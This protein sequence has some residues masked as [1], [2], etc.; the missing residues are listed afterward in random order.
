MLFFGILNVSVVVTLYFITDGEITTLLPFLLLYSCTI[1][2]ISL[3]FSKRSVKKAF[4]LYVL[5]PDQSYDRLYEWYRNIT[6]ELATKAGLKKMPEV[7]VYEVDD[8]NA[9]ATG[10]SK[11]SSLVAVSTSL[12]YEMDIDGIE[13]VI[14]HEIAHIKNGDMVTQTLL[15][16]F[17]NTLL[18]TVLLP[19][20]LFRWFLA[21]TIDRD[22]EWFVWLIWLLETIVAVVL[23]FVANLVAKMYSRRREFGADYLAAQLTNPQKMI[24]ALQQ[25]TDGPKLSPPQQK[26]AALQ[27]NGSKR[28]LDI[29]STHPSVERRIRYLQKKWL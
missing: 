25:L 5:Q 2:F 11:N 23:F 7:A 4:N 3:L 14:A 19:I 13:A 16:A 15:Q 18:A 26:Y 10:R 6:F 9:F 24:S 17:L 21:F 29:F 12:L 27:F 22:F 20:T 28:W 1:P 8:M